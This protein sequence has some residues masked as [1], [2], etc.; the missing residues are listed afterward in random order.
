MLTTLQVDVDKEVGGMYMLYLL[1]HVI[2]GSKRAGA[3]VHPFVYGYATLHS[4][5]LFVYIYIQDHSLYKVSFF[6]IFLI[7][8]TEL[9][10]CHEDNNIHCILV[11]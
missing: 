7:F 2:E 4:C 1:L 5:K 8:M 3:C 6:H 10:G 9:V 11:I